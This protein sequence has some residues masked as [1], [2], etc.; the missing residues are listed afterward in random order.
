MT[1]ELSYFLFLNLN[2]STLNSNFG[3]SYVMK[4]QSKKK[5]N[6]NPG[7]IAANYNLGIDKVIAIIPILHKRSLRFQEVK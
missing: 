1:M 6:P 2:I 3:L 5:K 4:K 7:L